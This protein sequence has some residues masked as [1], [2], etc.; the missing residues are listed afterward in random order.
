MSRP[1]RLLHKSFYHLWRGETFPIAAARPKSLVTGLIHDA[2]SI[3]KEQGLSL[4]PMYQTD[5]QTAAHLVGNGYVAENPLGEPAGT[6]S[7]DEGTVQRIGRTMIRFIEDGDTI[8]YARIGDPKT[9]LPAG[10]LL[11]FKKA[12]VKP[13]WLYDWY[14]HLGFNPIGL[15]RHPGR[16]IDTILMI[17]P[18]D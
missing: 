1:R 10:R 9:A 13:G 15:Y 12:A 3:W 8:D 4:G 2:F 14:V 7:L 11:V 5:E 16:Q 6:F 17:K 18:F